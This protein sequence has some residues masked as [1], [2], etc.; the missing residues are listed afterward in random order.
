MQKHRYALALSSML[1]AASAT[2]QVTPP[3]A[4]GQAPPPAPPTA[5]P[6]TPAPTQA[7]PYGAGMKVN[8]SPDGSKYLRFI[9]WHQVYTRYTENNS[10]TLRAPG[11]PQHGQVDFGLR[12][13][14]LV[15]LAQLN[16]RF[17][18]YTHL[19]I[20]NQNAVSGGAPGEA[21]GP[22]KKPQFFIHEA[23]TEYKVN[24]YLSLGAGLHYYNGIS[25]LSSASTVNILPMDL[26]LTNFPTIDALDQFARWMG[27]YAKGRIDKFDYRVSVSDPFLTNVSGTPLTLGATA[28]TTNTG[29][30]IAQ[31]NPQDTKH[32]YQGYFSYNFFEPEANVLPYQVGTYLGTKKVL[33]VGAGFMYNKDG[34]Y[35]RPTSS[36]VTVPLAT[37][38]DPFV[39]VATQKHDI[40]LFGVD[41]FYDVPLNKD[42]G[43]ALTLYGVY[44]N[45]DFGPNYVRYIGAENPG[46]GSAIPASVNPSGNLLRGNAIPTA[47]TGSSEYVQVGFLLPKNTL[48]PKALVQP[49]VT[50]LR[51]SYEGL[52]QSNGDRQTAKTVDAG[53]N[54]LLDGHNAKVTLNYRSRPDFTNVND[55]NYRPEITLQTQ[56]YL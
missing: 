33:S 47:G 34:T 38:A 37:G 31:F 12:R 10:G 41:A 4:G 51:G 21:T 48:G 49:Y 6:P 50:Y 36:A 46:Y 53:V 29:T 55:V 1:V 13:S 16:P 44:Y 19:G 54:L 18:L 20:N 7:V 8:I 24:K 27:V 28:G 26:P 17:L 15:I 25:R 22:G 40:K 35:S 30:N 14:R 11:K 32:V 23:V 56:V 52:R 9:S 2:A 39:A 3:P 43:T 42:A 5:P 45:F